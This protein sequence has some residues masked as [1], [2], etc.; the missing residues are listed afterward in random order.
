MARFNFRLQRV[1]DYRAGLEEEA[2]RAYQAAHAATGAEEREIR[3]V[4]QRRLGLLSL[5]TRNLD[6]RQAV[7]QCVLSL[8]QSLRHH[9]TILDQLRFEEEKALARWVETRRSLLSIEKLRDKAWEAWQLEETRREQRAMDEFA[10][11]RRAA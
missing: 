7:E 8:D 10:V 2:K 9:H 11:L 4:Q 3:T 1:L 5:E 6:E